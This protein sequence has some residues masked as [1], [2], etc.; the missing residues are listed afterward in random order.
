[1]E[2]VSPR[3]DVIWPTP[4]GDFELTFPPAD[5]W[6][7]Y[8]LVVFLL[9]LIR[10]L[11]LIGPY[12]AFLR[13]F[14]GKTRSWIKRVISIKKTT[15]LKGIYRLLMREII[16]LFLPIILAL[17]IRI[18]FG[19][20]GRLAWSNESAIFF[21][22]FGIIWMVVEFLRIQKTR[23]AILTIAEDKMY[24]SWRTGA[25]LDTLGFS[26]KALAWLSGLEDDSNTKPE[27]E[28]KEESTGILQSSLNTVSSGWKFGRE[29]VGTAAKFGK[30][31]LDDNLQNKFDDKTKTQWDL[32]IS[33]TVYSTLPLVV[34]YFLSWVLT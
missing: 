25:A 23:G 30:K 1:M 34:V 6:M 16:I 8:L 21:G 17:S 13:K 5:L 24:K 3:L 15:G 14:G 32:L 11:L 27:Q 20:P 31:K 12:D 22:I 18:S 7:G 19:H 9:V 28:V 26:S 33:D 4:F 10:I 2:I 29:K